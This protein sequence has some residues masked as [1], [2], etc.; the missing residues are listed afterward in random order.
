MFSEESIETKP[1]AY[2][3]IF[4]NDLKIPCNTNSSEE[5]VCPIMNFLEEKK[6]KVSVLS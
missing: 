3:K 1:E 2:L 6:I 4:F 5:T